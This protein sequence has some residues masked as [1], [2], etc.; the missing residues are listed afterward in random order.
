VHRVATPRGLW[1]ADHRQ[2]CSCVNVSV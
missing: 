2:G 1:C